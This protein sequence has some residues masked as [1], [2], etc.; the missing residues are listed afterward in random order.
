MSKRII[1]TVQLVEGD[2]LTIKVFQ[3][4]FIGADNFIETPSL[5]NLFILDIFK[6]DSYN[7]V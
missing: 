2:Y 4:A 7:F 5:G 1:Q 6:L 3:T